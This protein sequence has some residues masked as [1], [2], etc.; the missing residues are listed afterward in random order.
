MAAKVRPPLPDGP[1]LVVGMARS[2]TAVA[3]MLAGRGEAVIGCD[4]GRPEVDER[5]AAAGVEVSL[6][7]DGTE[8]LDSVATVVKSPGVP[9][10]APV[11]TAAR[12]LGKEVVGELELAWRCALGRFTAITGTNGKTTVTEWIGHA[13]GTAGRDTI[14]AGNVG[15]PLSSAVEEIGETTEVVCECSSFQLED[16]IAFSPEAGIL[17]NVSED[18]LDR[19]ATLD[20]YRTAKL[21][22][23]ANQTTGDLAI[24]DAADELIEPEMIGGEG[25]RAPYGPGC[26]IDADGAS[27]L[28]EGEPLIELAELPMPGE[29]NVRN[30]MAVTAACLAAGLDRAQTATGLR[31][32]PGIRHR[33]E[34]VGDLDGVLFVNDSK[35]TNVAAAAA[36][37]RSFDRPVRVILGG[38]LKGG[39]FAGLRAPVAERCVAAYLT[40]EAADAIAADLEGAGPQLVR[41]SGFDD[42][43]SRA[44]GDAREGEVVL[45]APA[46]ASFDEFQSYEERGDRFALLVREGGR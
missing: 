17:L 16:S 43:V 8:L 38:S 20:A 34:R 13:F 19:H 46:C 7:T 21:R 41:A 4:A 6:E 5:L 29:H 37:M 23:F 33:L 28:V 30:A 9:A 1:F 12:E 42:A 26:A 39:G 31:G 14:V 45:L 2:G 3:A 44:A 10:D 27:L 24:W 11:I 18:H 32:F 22:I 36:A 35:A 15:T 25:T 40:G